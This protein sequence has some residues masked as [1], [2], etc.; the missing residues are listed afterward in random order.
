MP[1]TES[2]ER[3][4]ER[5][6]SDGISIICCARS[7]AAYGTAVHNAGS[8]G[9]YVTYKSRL[10]HQLTDTCSNTGVWLTV[11]FTVERYISVCF[12]MKA[13]VWCTPKRARLIII[14]VCIGAA[15]LTV[16]EFFATTAITQVLATPTVLSSLLTS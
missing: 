10:G 16:P 12:P 2:V 13:I 8:S 11:T 15:V 5:E 9:L 6:I 7:C 3:E 1:L 4:R 14:A